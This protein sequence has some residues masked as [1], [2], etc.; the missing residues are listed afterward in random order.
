VTRSTWSKVLWALWMGGGGIAIAAAVY[1]LTGSVGWAIIALF[2]SGVVLNAIAQ[3]VIQPIKA[4]S[5]DR[6]K[7]STHPS[8]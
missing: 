5:A 2:A 7:R 4:A 3:M 1:S 6:S 8:K